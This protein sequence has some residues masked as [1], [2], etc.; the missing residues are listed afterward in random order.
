MDAE[1]LR[2]AG[3]PTERKQ[4]IRKDFETNLSYKI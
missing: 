2:L 1:K 3:S 4:V